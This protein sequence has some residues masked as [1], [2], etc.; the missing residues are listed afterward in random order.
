MRYRRFR[1]DERPDLVRQSA[2]SPSRPDEAHFFR[3]E[4]EHSIQGRKKSACESLIA[5]RALVPLSRLFSGGIERF[6]A[7]SA[8]CPRALAHHVVSG[9]LVGESR[10]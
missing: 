10:N 2:I 4:L 9:I 5:A 7:R 6:D 1:W 8:G 3:D